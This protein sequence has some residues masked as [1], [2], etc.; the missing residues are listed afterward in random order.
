M[1]QSGGLDE[2]WAN[3][4]CHL[5]ISEFQREP[6][7]INDVPVTIRCRY[8]FGSVVTHIDSTV[9]TS[10]LG[11]T[12]VKIHLSSKAVHRVEVWTEIGD[13]S[14][15]ES[16]RGRMICPTHLVVYKREKVE[17]KKEEG[18]GKEEDEKENRECDANAVK[19]DVTPS[20]LAEI[21]T[22]FPLNQLKLMTPVT[23]KPCDIWIDNSDSTYF[24]SLGLVF[25]SEGLR[26]VTPFKRIFLP[27]I[28]WQT[29]EDIFC[30]VGDDFD[31]RDAQIFKD[32]E[33]KEE[34]KKCK[35]KVIEEQKE[36]EEDKVKKEKEKEKEK[37]KGKEK[38]EE[39]EEKEKKK[40]K[41]EDIVVSGSDDWRTKRFI[42][43]SESS[44]ES[45]PPSS[46]LS[47]SLSPS[48]PLPSLSIGAYSIPIECAPSIS[49][50]CVAVGLKEI[51]RSS[52]TLKESDLPIEVKISIGEVKICDTTIVE[53]SVGSHKGDESKYDV[54][55]CISDSKVDKK[56][57]I[58]NCPHRSNFSDVRL[59]DVHSIDP[60]VLVSHF[61]PPHS[62]LPTLKSM[63]FPLFPLKST[64]T[65]S[66]F[67]CLSL[68][69]L[70]HISL[71]HLSLSLS[72]SLDL[73][74]W[75]NRLSLPSFDLTSVCS[76]EECEKLYGIPP[77]PP[78]VQKERTHK[79]ERREK[80][81]E[82]EKEKERGGEEEKRKGKGSRVGK[83]SVREHVEI[84]FLVCVC[85]CVRRGRVRRA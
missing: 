53:V 80:E 24:A 76:D 70:S 44:D 62:S 1:D 42:A 41:D 60:S 27:S 22:N 28:E 75:C 40:E 83:G 23:A 10:S 85:V 71:S 65:I 43:L 58:E 8:E 6:E 4:E 17:K 3:Q 61:Y 56:T 74:C 2:W 34:D 49:M 13:V 39:D 67:P 81:R 26:F 82:S 57:R 31:M 38:E 52:V 54:I 14:S 32:R 35:E 72:L 47:L 59:S 63:L 37:E 50:E 11:L 5:R 66:F 9:K 69:S 51:G 36:K 15:I 30:R 33:K 78:T 84:T 45:L 20:S 12:F 46:S 16:V 77:P 79:R 48:P 68:T 25:G 21:E 19:K 64:N 55:L 29:S 7:L 18:K 73:Q